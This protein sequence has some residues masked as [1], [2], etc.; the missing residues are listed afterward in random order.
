MVE[1]EV[2]DIVGS[3][4]IFILYPVYYW[5]IEMDTRVWMNEGKGRCKCFFIWCKCA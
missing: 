4:D 2:E 5:S 1:G 3:V